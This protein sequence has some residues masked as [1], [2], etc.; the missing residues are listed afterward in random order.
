[1]STLL[2]KNIGILQTPAGSFPHKGAQQGENMKLKD[3][4]VPD[5]LH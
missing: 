3:A 5:D 2:V 4:A 1:M